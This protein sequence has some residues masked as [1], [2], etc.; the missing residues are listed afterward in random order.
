M[1]SILILFSQIL[2]FGAMTTACLAQG[3]GF[4]YQG[5][6]V[7]N[8]TPANGSYDLEFTLYATNVTGS[9]IAGPVIESATPVTNGLFTVTIDFGPAFT[10]TNYWLE[11]GVRTNG[12]TPFNTLAPRQAVSP[13]PYAIYAS[14]AGSASTATTAS[15]VAAANLTGSLS[16]SQ[17]PQTVV[18]NGGNA[19]LSGVFS[20]NG[21]GLTNLN[22]ANLT[23]TPAIPGT[24][25]LVTAAITNGLATIPFVNVTAA[26]LA[27]TNF[28]TSQGYVTSSI[29]NG[30]AASVAAET[31]RATGAESALS[32]SVA[33]ETSR[34]T[35]AES[36]LSNGL[37][38]V[39]SLMLTNG[40]MGLTL[41]G[42]FNG[43]ANLTNGILSGVVIT[44]SIL[45]GDGSA[46][47]NLNY[48]NLT[49]TPAIPGTN[50]FVTAAIT[51]G[52]AT[53]TFVNIT[54]AP[55]ASTNFVTSQGYVT[56]NITNGVAASI[57]AETTRATTAESGLAASVIAET[58]RATGAESALSSSVATETSRATAAETGLSNGLSS[59][60]SLMLTNGATGIT[61]GGSF[62]GTANLTN[63][64]LT[65]V[66]IT[67]SILA[68]DGSALTNLQS[69][70]TQLYVWPGPT[71]AFGV[72]NFSYWT[73]GATNN[74]AITNIVGGVSGAVNFGTLEISNAATYTLTSTF[75]GAGMAHGLVT[76]NPVVIPAGKEAIWEFWIVG[77]GKTNF[78]NTP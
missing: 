7:N 61:L 34:A 12:A 71:N 18:T 30:V 56:S 44:N 66:V 72:T 40:A 17:L 31:T 16:Y 23:G 20:G 60:T 45:A 36:G 27:S 70:V 39:T 64:I 47:T 1:K 77:T 62:N 63:G 22:Y 24:N 32:T 57:A 50:G 14:N 76:S 42:T 54:T 68:G 29:T 9:S 26:P 35:T 75:T 13:T 58:T 25:G 69:P 78:M 4:T 8:G 55:L 28:V 48:A 2:L 5:Q 67:N 46:L 21:S 51:N 49:G 33:A 11:I 43:T 74:V 19:T 73:Y 65:G 53:V 3:T 15:A 6:L 59:V 38:S 41:G 10:G 37:S 52:L